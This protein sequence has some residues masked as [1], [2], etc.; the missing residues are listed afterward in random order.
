MQLLRQQALA[1]PA[2][3]AIEESTLSWGG[4]YCRP[5]QH[6]APENA[7]RGGVRWW[8]VTA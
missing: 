4:A 6:A 1:L 8:G 5:A 7:F 3:T 2:Y